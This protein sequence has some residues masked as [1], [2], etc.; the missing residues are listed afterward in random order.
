MALLLYLAHLSGLIAL[1]AVLH[2][3][4]GMLVPNVLV[5]VPLRSGLNL[6]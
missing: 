1:S 5:F 6:R 2:G 3:L 4:L